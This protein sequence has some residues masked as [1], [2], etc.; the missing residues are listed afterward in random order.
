MYLFDF[1][2][3]AKIRT[4]SMLNIIHPI[5]LEFRIICKIL[6][7]SSMLLIIFPI[8]MIRIPI[9]KCI[10]TIPIFLLVNKIPNIFLTIKIIILTM[11]ISFPFGIIVPLFNTTLITPQYSIPIRSTLPPYPLKFK[12]FTRICSFPIK[13]V[14]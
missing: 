3:F 9:L 7:S 5:S 10:S 14:I 2:K 6:C 13:F 4:L 12:I 1:S 8:S 11:P